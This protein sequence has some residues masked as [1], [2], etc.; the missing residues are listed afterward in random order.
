MEGTGAAKRGTLKIYLGY[1]A[2]VGK[3]YQMLEDAQE[4]RRQGNDLVIG[5]F[6]PHGRQ[7]TIAKTE[8]MEIVPRKR[9]SYRGTFFEEMDTESILRRKPEICLVDE[10]AHTNVPGSERTKR[11]EDV[12][13]LLDA[14]ITVLSTVNVQHLE[15]LNDQVWQLTGVRVRETLPDWV[16]DEADQ[17]V[18]V[19]L[20]PEALRNRIARGA[21]YPE[22]KAQKALEY[23]FKE[24]NLSALREIALRHAAHEMERPM[25]DSSEP[26]RLFSDQEI[27]YIEE[28]ILVCLGE[29]PSTAMLIRRARRVADYLKGTC[30]AIYV[31]PELNWDK[32]SIQH[33]ET[34]EQH[35]SFARNLR[36]ET[37]V[38]EGE[39]IAEAVVKF[40]RERNV[41]QIFMGRSD[42][43]HLPG[44]KR[45]SKIHRLVRLARDMEVTLVAERRRHQ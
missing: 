37:H 39:D 6:E 16:V 14:G 35:L 23:F 7:D 3:T 27:A 24:Q 4:L 19:D 17:V 1:A 25:P 44:F 9:I 29:K 31:L 10:L 11:W 45:N 41:T 21:V 13:I 22:D 12:L 15:S 20:T 42:T 40:A 26:Q 28:R 2:G 43:K 38:V 34:V 5:Y 30:L 36:I 8:G 32:I 33:R 18:L